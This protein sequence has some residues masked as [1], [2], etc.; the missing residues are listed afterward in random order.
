MTTNFAALDRQIDHLTEKLQAAREL[1]LIYRGTPEFD[2]LLSVL[3][4]TP[5]PVIT[6]EYRG[7]PANLHI[8][9]DTGL[10]LTYVFDGHTLT[11]SETKGTKG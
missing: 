3:D 4:G 11:L 8:V 6:V 7:D 1:C 9:N 2:A 10:S 5:T